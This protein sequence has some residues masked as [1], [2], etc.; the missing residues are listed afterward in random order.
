MAG[1]RQRR[2][3]PLGRARSVAVVGL[4][5]LTVTVEAHVASGLPGFHLIGSS[6]TAARQAADR[7][8]TA[9]AAVG[10]SLPQRKVLVSLAPA[11]VPKAGARFDLAVAAAV[12][13]QLGLLGEQVLQDTALLG[14]LA[15]DGTV[16][17]VPA[18]LPSAASLP[19][20]GVRRL[21]VADGNAPE[22]ALVERLEVV[23]VAHL[24]EA[25]AVLRGEQAARAVPEPAAGRRGLSGL[26]DLAEVRGQTEARRA[27]EVAAAGGHHL[28]LLGPPG[29]GKS[30][31][32]RRLPTVLPPLTRE[33]ALEVAAVRSVAGRRAGE[34]DQPILD[35]TPPFRS[36]HHRTSTAALLGGG[37]GIARPGELS[38]AHR[39]V[40]F[41][42]ELLEWSRSLLD[43][44]R[45]PLEEGV[46]RVARAQ[47]TVTYPAHVQV[48][49]ASNPCPCGGGQG[50]MCSDDVVWA[51]RARLSGPLADRLDL[52]PS[53]TP[54]S[55]GDLLD[56]GRAESSAVV[57]ARVGAARALAAERW[58][59]TVPG[60]P[61]GRLRN[62]DAPAAVVR[63][64]A[65]PRALQALATAVEAG[66]LTG[67]GYDR[68]LR[69]ARTCADLDGS[70]VITHDHVLEAWAARLALRP[71]PTAFAAA[72]RSDR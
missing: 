7:V 28:L 62:V 34:E 69:V 47:G 39:G 10:V 43:S 40:L 26:G 11:E 72:G 29:C 3:P 13:D 5:A 16:R 59:T 46:V 8:R 64:S 51:Y 57:A 18:V 17:P 56:S 4:R 65:H 15:L 23:P 31:L 6:G 50:C 53:V 32:A 58:G 71:P 42:D 35:L 63:Q 48:V 2:P 54:L 68:T 36:P 38:L 33:Q 49:A 14:E 52:A 37:S 70:D 41:L 55:A 22:A 21:L 45:E 27:L 66:E 19:P 60:R 24:A 9:L 20:A 25:L 61:P 67:R 1:E 44:L 12:L 30:M